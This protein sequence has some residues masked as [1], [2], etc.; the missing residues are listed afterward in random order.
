MDDHPK[1]RLQVVAPREYTVHV[2]TSRV[3]FKSRTAEEGGIALGGHYENKLSFSTE[4]RPMINR[5]DLRGALQYITLL[6]RS[7]GCCKTISVNYFTSLCL[8]LRIRRE[9]EIEKKNDRRFRHGSRSSRDRPHRDARDA[10]GSRQL[11]AFRCSRQKYLLLHAR[12]SRRSSKTH[13]NSIAG[14]RGQAPGTLA[15]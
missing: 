5:R 8:F 10:S 1:Q 6:T 4:N 9:R 13:D 12:L 15:L 2:Y 11:R 3:Y 7:T 14:L